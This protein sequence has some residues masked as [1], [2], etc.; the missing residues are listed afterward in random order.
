MGIFRETKITADVVI[1]SKWCI[2]CDQPDELLAIQLWA[3]HND[4]DVQVVRT[5][6]KPAD[7]NRAVRLW[8][9]HQGVSEEEAQDYPAFVVRDSIMSLKDFVEMIAKDNVKNKMVK[10][11]KSKDDL[12][13]LPKAKRTSRARRVARPKDKD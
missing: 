10:E 13:G 2:S 8:A 1:Y 4:L 5:A 6:Y 7:H 11:G 12:Q 9:S 3:L